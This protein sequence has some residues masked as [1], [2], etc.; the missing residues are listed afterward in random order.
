MLISGPEVAAKIAD[1]DVET[2][3]QTAIPSPEVA[4]TAAVAAG[5]SEDP[6]PPQVTE[7]CHIAHIIFITL[8][9]LQTFELRI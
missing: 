5:L 7:Y 1:V 9:H 4:V 2:G 6:P 3:S 8:C